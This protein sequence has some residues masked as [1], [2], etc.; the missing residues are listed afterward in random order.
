[1]VQHQTAPKRRGKVTL[2]DIADECGVALST[3][4]LAIGGDERVKD[5][6]AEM[7]QSVAREM[8]Y[9]R[10]RHQSA[11]RMAAWRH[12]RDLLHHVVGG[13]FPFGGYESPSLPARPPTA[14]RRRAK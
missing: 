6:T 11:R 7:I 5:S 4:S 14:N 13:L 9:E 12:G 2:Q 3:V 10:S 1:M 8:G